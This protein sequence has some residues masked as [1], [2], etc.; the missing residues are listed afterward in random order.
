MVELH[1]LGSRSL[2]QRAKGAIMIVIVDGGDYHVIEDDV[3]VH[4]L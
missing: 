4:R 3:R 2:K 1:L